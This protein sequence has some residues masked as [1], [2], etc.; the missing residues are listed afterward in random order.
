VSEVN[1]DSLVSILPKRIARLGELAYNLWWTWQ[2][3][4]QRMFRL[5][6]RALWEQIYHNPVK[7]L[8]Q[9]HRKRLTTA[10][11]DKRFLVLYDQVI[12]E[13]DSYM[14]AKANGKR[15]KTWFEQFDRSWDPKRG[16]VAYFSFEFGLHEV[17]PMYAGGLG[18]LAA[19]HLKEAS[20]MGLPLTGVGFLYLQGYFRQ[21][22][23]EDGWQEAQFEN[24]DF[25]QLPITPVHDEH[26][27]P[28]IIS[29]ALPGR[30]VHLRVWKVQVGR[31]PLYLLDSDLPDNT[32][33]D[34]QLT[35]RLYSPDPDTRIDQELLLGIGGVRALAALKIT[36]AI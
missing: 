19:D 10:S 33:N 9:V 36:P 14:S 28:L 25:E 11:K 27:D 23:T 5:L 8:R 29:V 18:I 17:L 3:E 32:Q 13:F 35:Q 15:A 16:P 20:D 12:G 22:I 31:V 34:R 2:P 24:Y 26:D 30:A 7:M 21:R 1:V 6:D 4:A